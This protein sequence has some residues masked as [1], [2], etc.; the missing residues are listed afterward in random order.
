MTKYKVKILNN[1]SDTKLSYCMSSLFISL[2]SC[3]NYPIEFRRAALA[4]SYKMHL[5]KFRPKLAQKS[6]SDMLKDLQIYQEG[7]IPLIERYLVE[8]YK[9]NYRCIN[10]RF[11]RTLYEI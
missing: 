6:N 7:I 2:R 8:H 11:D 5:I 9:N 4:L 10:N 1:H 3:K